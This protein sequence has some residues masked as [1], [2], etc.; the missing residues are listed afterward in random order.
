[1]SP[2]AGAE[3]RSGNAAQQAGAE[4][5]SGNAAQQARAFLARTV[6]ASATLDQMRTR[7]P[8]LGRSPFWERS[9]RALLD[10][11]DLSGE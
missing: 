1:M 4:A 10:P 8:E 6:R 2:G 3:A 5:R 11:E 7:S 9:S